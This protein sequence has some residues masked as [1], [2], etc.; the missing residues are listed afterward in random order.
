MSYTNSGDF[1][2]LKKIKI[3]S[4]IGIFLLSFL[5][6]FMYDWFPC[7]LTSLL[8]PVNESIWEHMK[9]LF[10]GTLVFGVFEYILLRKYNVNYNNFYFSLFITSVVSFIFYLIVYLPLYNAYGENMF[11]SIFLLFITIVIFQCISFYILHS[12]HFKYL[13]IMSILLMIFTFVIFIYFTYNPPENYVFF[14]IISN[15]Y[16]IK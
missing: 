1:M 3:V 13:N 14:D 7:L 12:K 11:I 4:I 9:L 16:G 10:I 8:F 5:F 15:S 6:H 2:S